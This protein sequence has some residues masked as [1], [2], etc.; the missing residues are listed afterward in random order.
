MCVSVLKPLNYTQGR[1][2]KQPKPAT[3]KSPHRDVVG[4]ARGVLRLDGLSGRPYGA[5]TPTPRGTTSLSSEGR[6]RMDSRHRKHGVIIGSG[7][8]AVNC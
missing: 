2:A 6:L 8:G 4:L 3:N 7:G 5:S 1:F